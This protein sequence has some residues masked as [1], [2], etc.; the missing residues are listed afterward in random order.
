LTFIQGVLW[1]WKET[2]ITHVF[3]F[4]REVEKLLHTGGC[5]EY[6]TE[7][8]WVNGWRKFTVFRIYHIEWNQV[9]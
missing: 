4:V 7:I 5:R 6:R 9:T 3:L 2:L 8:N 1:W